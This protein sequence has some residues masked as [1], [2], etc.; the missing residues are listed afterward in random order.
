MMQEVAQ[1]AGVDFLDLHEV[2]DEDY[3][4]NRRTFNFASDYH[5]NEYAHELAAQA[6]YRHIAASGTASQTGGR[7]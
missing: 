6:V 1:E 2:F 7:H 4:R 5:W 3:R